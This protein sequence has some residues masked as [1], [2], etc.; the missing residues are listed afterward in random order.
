MDTR[1][2]TMYHN[3]LQASA[4]EHGAKKRTP[5]IEQPKS[6]PANKETKPANTKRLP[7]QTK[8][9]T[10]PRRRKPCRSKCLIHEM[11]VQAGLR[12]QCEWLNPC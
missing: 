12:C 1:S 4:K 10:A 5:T 8:T 11:L 7:T 6:Q 3:L 9:R 2:Q